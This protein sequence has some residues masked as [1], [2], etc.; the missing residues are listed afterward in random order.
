MPLRSGSDSRRSSMCRRS[1]P[2][3]VQEPAAT[4]SSSGSPSPQPSSNAGCPDS[5]MNSRRSRTSGDGRPERRVET[6]DETGVEVSGIHRDILPATR[7]LP[8]PGEF[9]GVVPRRSFQALPYT[10]RPGLRRGSTAIRGTGSMPSCPP[11]REWCNRARRI[12]VPRPRRSRC[13]AP[14]SVRHA[15][16]PACSLSAARALLW[17]RTPRGISTGVAACGP[18]RR[19]V[20][21]G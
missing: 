4:R 3:D 7:S 13:A 15:T 19:T 11:R 8:D 2:V 10:C 6:G 14:R 12:R 1:P 18:T 17:S 9:V 5:S 20:G 16:L 21:I